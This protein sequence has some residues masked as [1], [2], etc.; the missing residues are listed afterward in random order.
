MISVRLPIP[1]SVNELF[2]NA[3]QQEGRKRSKG[4]IKTDKY[5]G[6]IKDAGWELN[7]QRARPMK[8]KVRVE[9]ALTEDANCDLDNATKAILD[10][11]V[12][13]KLIEGDSKK[14]VRRIVQYWESTIRAVNVTVYP[15]L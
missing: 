9:I 3:K 6:W 10:L 1:P 2:F 11:L 4:R 13:H 14:H 15:S 8:G 12:S 5:K 7:I